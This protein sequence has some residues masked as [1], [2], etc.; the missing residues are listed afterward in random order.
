MSIGNTFARSATLIVL[1]FAAS[2]ALPASARALPAIDALTAISASSPAARSAPLSTAPANDATLQI[3][4]RFGVPTFLWGTTAATTLKAMQRAASTKTSLDEEGTA[5]A[6]L[7]DVADLYRI[8]ASEVDALS[9]HNLQRFPNGAAIVRFR[10][11][12][13]GIEVF[14]EQANVLLDKSGGLVAVGGFVM[15]T[16]ANQRKSAQVFT[17][18]PQQAVATALRDYGFPSAIADDLQPTGERGGYASLALPQGIVSSDGSALSDA[19]RVKRMW[20]RLLTGL[21]AAYYVEVQMR[22]GFWPHGVDYYAYVISATDGTVLFRHNQ[23]SD[24]AFSYRV[25][26]EPT[27]ANLPLPSPAGRNAFPHPTGT[28]DGYQAPLVAPNLITLQNLPF[29]KNDPWLSPNAT[30][31]IGN[32][33]DAFSDT[34]SPDN[35]N[36]PAVDECNV[37]LPIDGDLHACTNAATTLDYVYDE[38]Q[39]PLAS[40]AQVMA[41]VTNLFYTINYL[42]DWY[43]DAGFDEAAGNAQANNY[44][45][46][47]IDLDSIYAEAQNFTGTNNA[48]MSTPADGQRP[49]MRQFLWNSSIALVTLVK[50]NAPASIA[51]T[52]QSGV[53]DFGPQVF[54]VTGDLVL[55]LDAANTTGPTTTDGC[56]AFT[57]AAAIAGKIAVI[58]RGVCLF[59]EKARNAQTA[60]A[61]GVLILNNVSPGAPGMAGTDATITIPVV[62]VSLADGN[63][64]KAALAAPSTVNLRMARLPIV[65]RDGA[66]DSTLIA[67]EW[68]HYLSNRLVGDSNGLNANQARGMGEGWS[69]FNALLLLVKE[70]D[71]ALPA[72]ASFDGTY[73]VTAYPLSGPDFAPD[74]L[75]NANY[76]GIRRYPYSRDMTRNPLTFSHIT[77]GVPLPT[78]PAPSLRNSSSANSQVHNTGEVWASMLWECYSNL[79]NDTARLTFAQAQ[80]RMKRYLVGGFKM[81]PNDPT[82]I[83]ARDALL[84]VMQAQDPQDRNL[85][86]QGFAK[87]GAGAGAVAP[88]NLSEDNAGVVESYKVV[89]DPGVKSPVVEYYHAAFDHYFI[90]NIA[91]EITKLDNGTLVGWARTGESFNVYSDAPVGSS[92]V[93]R[94]FGTSFGLKSSHFYTP[95]ASEC[96]TVKQ[97]PE[98]LFEAVVFNTPTPDINGNCPAGTLP[99]YRLYNDGQGAAPNHRFTTSLVTRAQ[100]LAKK[101]IPEGNG[102]GVSMCSPT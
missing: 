14:R 94:F 2:H 77:D 70:S 64:I 29:S 65:Q 6:H 18:T 102:I 84:A 76:Y 57:N 28:P 34:F 50:V 12:I 15:G 9:M 48:S 54:D 25:Y 13:D 69:D 79:L 83:T 33:V 73:P 68:G 90:T 61:I 26:A 82:F 96:A 27:G 56:T 60:G 89:A 7:R 43:Y 47:G 19:A 87:R 5:R 37:S 23:T 4:P 40:R 24:V 21:A 51:G 80:D 36:P 95:S 39:P 31:T 62:S 86:L 41:A 92:R 101:W 35:F 45:R 67:H 85:C 8:T 42:H 17:T 63:A 16:P 53:A 32:N 72:N 99:V 3:D 20:F 59:I 46:G 88:D 22:D 66:L 44:G 55:A 71:R 11:P 74:A 49:R 98:W 81:T 30:R 75:N 93:C 10:N 78:S 58:D 1:A 97:K 38:N 100:M 91:D 52:K